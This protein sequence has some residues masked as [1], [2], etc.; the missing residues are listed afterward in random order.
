[1]GKSD[2]LFG[3]DGI[4]GQVNSHPV[5]A[6]MALK[7]GLAL[8]LRLQAQGRAPVHIVMGRD[9]RR[10][11]VML[12]SALSSGLMAAG[13]E[14]FLL[15]VLP[16]PAVAYLT[17]AL[18]ADCGLMITASHNAAQ[19]N[20]IKFFG[21][22]GFKLSD[23]VETEL[24]HLVCQGSLDTTHLGHEQV[25]QVHHVSDAAARYIEFA[26]SSINHLSLEH[27]KVVIDGAHG[28][29]AVLAPRIF[30]ELGATVI[31]TH[32]QPNGLNINAACGA[33]YPAAMTELVREHGADI[34]IAL[35]GDADRVIFSDAQGT[36]LAGDHVL[37][38]CALALHKAGHLK[39]ETVVTTSMS[40]TGLYELM[41]QNNIRVLT[42]DVGDR[43]VI[44]AMRRGNYVL[45]GESSGHLIFKNHATTGDGIISALQLLR[46]MQDE[47]QS[48]HALAQLM[49]QYPQKILSLPVR[50]QLPIAVVVPLVAAIAAC[51]AAL[52]QEGR[53]V[54]RYSGT[55]PK[56]RFLVEAATHDLVEY[57]LTKLT[58]A[59][60]DGGIL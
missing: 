55:E 40:N 58:R 15:G 42:T 5:T 56:I 20:G 30:R 52:G 50:Q 17:K 14:V 33:L 22:D 59:A 4:R 49:R 1:M 21:A 46:I 11:G 28:A 29:A 24:E 26:K 31:A 51:E 54:V 18:K 2:Q 27:Y 44:E 39:N 48:L 9:T 45:G 60:T 19:D 25:G 13:C 43:F 41:R 10:S 34:G 3:T 35:D 38:I 57:W 37:A 53:V 12:E 6:T 8:G 47:G 7:L 32:C 16:T 36:V 23:A